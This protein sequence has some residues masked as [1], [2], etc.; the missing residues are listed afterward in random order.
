[1]SHSE[2]EPFKVS[3]R[4]E[5]PFCVYRGALAEALIA[6]MGEAKP[7]QAGGPDKGDGGS[8]RG[9]AGALEKVGGLLTSWPGGVM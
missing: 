2:G 3:S 4:G 9:E 6:W 5:H 8:T 7:E 1:M